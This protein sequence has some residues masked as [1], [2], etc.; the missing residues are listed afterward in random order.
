MDPTSEQGLVDLEIEKSKAMLYAAGRP[1]IARSRNLI[2][3]S[4]ATLQ[5]CTDLL[6][7]SNHCL[8]LS[9]S[10]LYATEQ[11]E[12]LVERLRHFDSFL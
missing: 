4:L 10:C 6:Q 5:R 7:Q 9:C 12:T 3:R 8:V 2:W 11:H 1:E